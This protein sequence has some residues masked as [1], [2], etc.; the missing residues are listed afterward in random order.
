MGVSLQR[1]RRAREGDAAVPLPPAAA[2]R[3]LFRPEALARLSTPQALDERLHVVPGPAAIAL[4]ACLA[5]AGLTLAWTLLGT[6]RVTVTGAGVLHREGG[7]FVDVHAP[8]AGW[9]DEIVAHGETIGVGDLIARLRAPEEEARVTELESRV[10]RLAG[11]RQ[12]VV[13]RQA[14]KTRAETR[15]AEMRRQG[16]T[17]TSQLSAQRAQEL[18]QLLGT[19]EQLRLTGNSTAERVLEARERLLA[20]REAASRARTD[21]QSIDT[22]LLALQT[23]HAQEL[24]A[25]DREEQDFKGQLAQA[26]LALAL[27]TEVRAREPGEVMMTPV[28]RHSLVS[29][30]QQLVTYETG[31]DHLEALLYLAPEAGKRVRPGMDVQVSLT[32]A[33]REEYGSVLGTVRWVSPVP[34][35]QR[36]IADRLSNPDLARKLAGDGSPIAVSVALSRGR[37]GGGY[38]WTSSR[39][40]DVA[41]ESGITV[42][43]AVTVRSAPPISFA[44]PALRR[45]TGL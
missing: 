23:T 42:T 32:S 3:P 33:K 6:M 25:L 4:A 18:E 5:L 9:V 30:G 28:T 29:A 16:F 24:E 19:R 15:L 22:G 35:T 37:E 41:M 36:E 14:E 20:A 45:W 26:R 27:A 17:E 43:G 31:R 11:R 21:L 38:L 8:K 39:G 2:P 12:E 10:A 40:A 34:Q 13:A 44:I 7:L 1:H